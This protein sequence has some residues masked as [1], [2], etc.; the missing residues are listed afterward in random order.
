MLLIKPF[1]VYR[2]NK[3][4]GEGP[5][6]C[7]FFCLDFS[8]LERYLEILRDVEIPLTLTIL[9][10]LNLIISLGTYIYLLVPIYFCLYP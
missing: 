10:I 8:D 7:V 4:V 9:F 1:Q 6:G 3:N 2:S 5:F